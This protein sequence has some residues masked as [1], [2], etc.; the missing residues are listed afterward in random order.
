MNHLCE[1]ALKQSNAT[2]SPTIK[3]ACMQKY[4]F[5][6]PPSA[7]AVSTLWQLRWARRTPDIL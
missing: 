5:A 6:C 2:E 3:P 7:F 4:G 1:I